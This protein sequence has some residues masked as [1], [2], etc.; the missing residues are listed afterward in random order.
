MEKKEINIEGLAG[1]L[2]SIRKDN[3]LTQRAVAEKL[4]ISSTG[5]WSQ[6]ELGKKTPSDT[7]LKL[8]S[9]TFNV[10]FDWLKHGDG[11]RWD[12]SGVFELINIAS[13]T[14]PDP[15]GKLEI[16][17]LKLALHKTAQRINEL[18]KDIEI[19]DQK[20]MDLNKR[21]F[22]EEIEK[23]VYSAIQEVSPKENT[24]KLI[25]AYLEELLDRKETTGYGAK[26]RPQIRRTAEPELEVTEVRMNI[27]E[28][29]EGLNEDEAAR[30]E[31]NR[32][33]LERW[34]NSEAAIWA[35]QW[36]LE[37]FCRDVV[38]MYGGGRPGEV[39][40][41]LKDFMEEGPNPR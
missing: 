25:L 30:W 20:I 35:P 32:G 16:N 17:N 4:S 31:R 15:E 7:L 34:M 12:A 11:G 28:L 27:P 38:E 33:V 1:R 23:T 37:R 3:L 22:E 41:L 21:T 6:L 10:R 13:K 5:Y 2:K 24:I 40:G 26:D 19:R 9:E 36:A 18:E 39:T 14:F 29:P 8:I